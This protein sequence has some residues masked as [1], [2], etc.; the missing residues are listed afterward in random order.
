M[1]A[2]RAVVNLRVLRGGSV[3]WCAVEGEGPGR[4]VP[5]GVPLAGR[6]G[7]LGVFR[8]YR[9]LWCWYS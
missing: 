4:G 1:L 7:V 2:H 6:R 3:P 8:V 9:A 5:L